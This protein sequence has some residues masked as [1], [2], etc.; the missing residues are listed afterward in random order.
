[1]RV[2]IIPREKGETR[3]GERAWAL[4]VVPRFTLS[5]PRF[6]FLA[7]GDSHARLRFARS[8]IPEGN[9]D[10]SLSTDSISGPV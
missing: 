5:P 3:R 10:Y 8:T 2:K 1:M 9:G 7:W 6:A 4:S